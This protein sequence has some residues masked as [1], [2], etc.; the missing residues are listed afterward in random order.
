YSKVKKHSREIA[1]WLIAHSY[2]ESSELINKIRR[3]G[4]I[5]ILESVGIKSRE[6]ENMFS[7]FNSH[8][9]EK[10]DHIS[11]I[12]HEV[13]SRKVAS[14][15]EAKELE[16]LMWPFCIEWFAARLVADGERGESNG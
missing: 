16:K 14:E 8:L 4:N 15:S 5:D 13:I 10:I 12:A 6:K 11:N 1:R 3:F 9:A 7:D 2:L